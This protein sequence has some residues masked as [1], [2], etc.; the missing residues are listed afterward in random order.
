MTQWILPWMGNPPCRSDLASCSGSDGWC[1]RSC[2]T[3]GRHNINGEGARPVLIL[4]NYG[5][6]GRTPML[7]SISHP[8]KAVVGVAVV[9]AIWL[10]PSFPTNMQQV[11]A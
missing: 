3:K 6:E 5:K 1:S 2:S 10:M 7:A 9:V 4:G 11:N 8:V